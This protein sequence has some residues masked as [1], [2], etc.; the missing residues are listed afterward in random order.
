MIK[1]KGFVYMKKIVALVM[2]AALLLSGCMY[3][4]SWYL[5]PDY[6]DM[7]YTRPDLAA[8][9]TLLQ[10]SCDG[11]AKAK[12]V[13]EV[14]EFVY[15]FYDAYDSF[16]TNY[17]LAYICYCAD[18]TDIY[19][20]QEYDFCAENTPVA[21]AGLEQLYR[22]L[23]RCEVRS[24]LESPD[25][26]GEGFF[27]DYDGEAVWDEG[28]TALMTQ[29]AEILDRY[30]AVYDESS[31]AEYASEEFYTQYAP[32]M[33]EIYVEL[34]A[35]RRQI[36]DYMGYKTYSQ[37]A[38][39]FYYSRDYTPVQAVEYFIQIRDVLVPLYTR[40]TEDVWTGIEN[41]CTPEQA[42]RYTGTAATAMGGE[43]AEAFSL[44]KFR[45]LYDID[46]GENKYEISFETFLSSYYTPFIFMCSTGTDY[47]K[48]T[49]VHEFGHFVNDYVCGGSMAGTDVTEVH[50]QAMEYLSLCYSDADTLVRFKLADCLSTY[51]EQ[52]AFALFEHRVYALPAEEL[53]AENVQRI[54]TQTGTEFGFTTWDWDE[55][56]FVLTTHYFTY[57]MYIDS[58]VVSND[59]AF[60]IY[61][62]EK[63]ETG[64]G[65]AVYRQCISSQDSYLL[66][67]ADT[68]G[69]ESPFAEGRIEQVAKVLAEALDI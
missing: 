9:D 39:D 45:N 35:L 8:M 29:E 36:A 23:A 40:L 25:Y 46:Y 41:P 10:Q 67:F 20:E 61:Q 52:A 32:R 51:V 59:L 64:A 65:L 13:D 28:F 58:Y 34:V 33:A 42:L 57:P 26:F 50:S 21:D 11:I 68:Y 62:L 14:L 18:M 63:E 7:E 27:E 53:T 44:L 47:D 1:E 6:S 17:D 38:Y 3:M 4:G 5:Y 24:L 43:I 66:N 48:L 69:L 30:Y 37:F 15:A 2:A 54:Y 56:D 22:A 16:Y 19:W 12:T 55:R 31:A 49:L 60:Q